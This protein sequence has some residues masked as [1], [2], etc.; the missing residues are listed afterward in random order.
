MSRCIAIDNA[1]GALTAAGVPTPTG[2]GPDAVAVDPT[3]SY[4]YVANLASNSV[5]AYAIDSPPACLTELSNSPFAVGAEPTSLK[6]DPNGNFLYVTNFNDGNV[7]VLAID[8]ATGSLSAISGSPF[9]AGAGRH[10][11]RHRSR[12]NLCLR[13]Q[14][15]GRQHLRILDQCID[16][17][18]DGRIRIAAW[19]PEPAPNRWPSTRRAAIV[20]I[21]NVTAKTR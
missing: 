8:P 12:G 11:D 17:R 13:R 20:Y 6:I 14:R 21:A 7:T 18:A 16:R 5:S 9:G 4:L 10:L 19:P 2:S 15:N 1:T 3:D